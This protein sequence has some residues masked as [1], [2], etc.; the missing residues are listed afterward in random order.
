[1]GPLSCSSSVLVEK[2]SAEGVQPWWPPF[3]SLLTCKVGTAVS[4][5]C[6]PSVC[7]DVIPGLESM[8]LLPVSSLLLPSPPELDTYRLYNVALPRSFCRQTCRWS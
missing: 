3:F 2:G 7:N 4:P 5:H 1:M 6:E 8:A